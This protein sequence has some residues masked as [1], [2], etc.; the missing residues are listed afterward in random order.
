MQIFF[1]ES[2]AL[3]GTNAKSTLATPTPVNVIPEFT[4][5]VLGGS[6]SVFSQPSIYIDGWLYG[7]RMT[8]VVCN[9]PVLSQNDSTYHHSVFTT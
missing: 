1:S 2:H 8:S 4:F 3:T 7:M 9:V 6:T 5:T